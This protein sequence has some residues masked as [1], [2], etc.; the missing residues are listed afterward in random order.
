M[1]AIGIYTINAELPATIAP[2]QRTIE[3]LYTEEFL[4]LVGRQ[5][6]LYLKVALFP[7]I[8]VE[9]KRRTYT[10]KIVEVDLIDRFILRWREIQLI[11]H[12]VRQ[13][14]GLRAGRFITQGFG[15]DGHDHQ[16]CHHHQFLHIHKFLGCKY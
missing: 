6:T 14:Q 1:S 8:A 13:E 12:L 15:S 7:Q 2:T 4:I 5:H 11:G 16:E 3:I 10:H 9:I